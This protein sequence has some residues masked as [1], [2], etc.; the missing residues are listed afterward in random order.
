MQSLDNCDVN[1]GKA[2]NNY[3]PLFTPTLRHAETNCQGN[4]EYL[5][6]FFSCNLVVLH[7]FFFDYFR[8]YVRV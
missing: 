5:F 8:Y 4:F 3:G 1:S 6:L 7:A 2:A